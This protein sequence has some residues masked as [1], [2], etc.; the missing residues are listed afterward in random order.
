MATITPQQETWLKQALFTPAQITQLKTGAAGPELQNAAN[1]VIQNK[2]SF[3]GGGTSV[4]TNP[5][6]GSRSVS[7]P[8]DL[9]VIGG[10]LNRA[11]TTPGTSLRQKL[12]GPVPFGGVPAT[13][14]L[15]PITP[16]PAPAKGYPTTGNST[17]YG[18][19]AGGIGGRFA[20]PSASRNTGDV[21]PK[22]GGPVGNRAA[23]P[24]IPDAPSFP[25]LPPPVDPGPAIPFPEAPPFP[26]APSYPEINVPD[27]VVRDFLDKAKQQ[28]AEAYAPLYQ[29]LD[30]G[31]QNATGNQQHSDA[32]IKGLYEGLAND[33]N[34]AGVAQSQQ[35]KQS[36]Q[37]SQAVAQ[38]LQNKIGDIYGGGDQQTSDFAASLGQAPAGQEAVAQ[39]NGERQFQQAEAATS[40]ANQQNFYNQGAAN[41]QN[42][43]TQMAGAANTEGAGRRSDL[44]KQLNDVLSQYDQQKLGYKSEEA[45]G[46][47]QQS[48]V[49]SRQDLET[50]QNRINNILSEAGINDSR[51]A[52]AY[53]A[54]IQAYEAKYGYNK[55]VFNAQTGQ[56]QSDLARRDAARQEI[57]GQNT[58][59]YNDQMARRDAQ[60]AAIAA[61]QKAAAEAQ[62]TGIENSQKDAQI[63]AQL[64]EAGLM[65]DP[66]N[67]GQ[68]IPITSGASGAPVPG[69]PEFK[70]ASSGA[71]FIA[72]VNQM[73]PTAN[74]QK[75]LD[76]FNEFMSKHDPAQFNPQSLSF[77]AAQEAEGAGLNAQIVSKMAPNFWS[78]FQLAR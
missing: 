11:P 10:A 1:R 46:A 72:M 68:Y 69:T 75:Y 60:M 2:G 44:V 77:Q 38:A 23:P 65:P 76:F 37:E 47:I 57:I 51:I 50:Q 3:L 27:L 17:N 22:G 26:D 7:N 48:N 52:S 4:K 59:V 55:D 31:K 25:Q 32:V 62:Q 64:R 16:M 42:Y 61:A 8:F 66:N 15:T 13:S 40:G 34:A 43:N 29:A 36:G 78:L 28:Y 21:L 54:A 67:E 19:G 70:D 53:S 35:Y 33:F 39:G 5:I 30:I 63:L 74:G 49:L 24:L 45:Q 41:A 71:Q 9:G 6:G 14:R 20:L 12:S 18:T 56:Q 58:A 73:D